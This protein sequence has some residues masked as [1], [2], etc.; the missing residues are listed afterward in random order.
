MEGTRAGDS[1]D[2]LTGDFEPDLDAI[3][4]QPIGC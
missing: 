3:V 1:L 2:C 4:L